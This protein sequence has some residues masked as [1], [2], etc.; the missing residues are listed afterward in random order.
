V[1]TA[2]S[3]SLRRRAACSAFSAAAV[4]LA[5]CGVTSNGRRTRSRSRARDGVLEGLPSIFNLAMRDESAVIS[6]L[7]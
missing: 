6:A 4:V 7:C 5:T 2:R 3:A 1:R